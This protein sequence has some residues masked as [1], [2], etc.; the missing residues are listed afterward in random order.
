[1]VVRRRSRKGNKKK[2]LALDLGTHTGMACQFSD[3]EIKSE[4]WLCGIE[5]GESSGMRYLKFQSRLVGQKIIMHGI[6]LVVYEKPHHRGGAPTEYLLG[7]ATHLQSFCA[8][9]NIEYTTVH[10]A[11]L[12]KQTTGNGRA[13]KKDMIKAA[14][15]L[16]GKDIV[17]DNEADAVCILYYA[18]NKFH[19]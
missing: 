2:I 17:S 15:K 12:K 7:F 18:K 9:R 13:S 14:E 16:T 4:E 1:M 19:I 3:G 10:T 11:T 5:R 6:D 8:K